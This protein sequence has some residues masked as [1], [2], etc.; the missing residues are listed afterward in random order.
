[1]RDVETIFHRAASLPADERLRYLNAACGSD[2]ALRA[3]VDGLLQADGKAVTFMAGLEN[4]LHAVLKHHQE[5]GSQVGRYRIDRKI[6]AGGMG[7]VYQAWDEKLNRDVALKFLHPHSALDPDAKERFLREARAIS[8]LNHPNICTVFD[9][10]ETD[11]DEQYIVMEFCNGQ[12]LDELIDA[13]KLTYDVNFAIAEQLCDALAIAHAGDILHRDLKPQN[14]IIDQESQVKLLDFGIAKIVEAGAS[15]TSRALGTVSYMSPEQFNAQEQDERTD[16]W[17]LGIL[18]FEMLTGVTPFK[19]KTQPEVMRAIFSKQRLSLH[20][21]GSKLPESFERFFDTCLAHS[22]LDRFSHMNEVKA[23]LS[24]LRLELQH[25]GLANETPKFS[26]LAEDVH[27]LGRSSQNERR[28]ITILHYR[29]LLPEGTDPEDQLILVDQI[30]EI[31]GKIIRRFGAYQYSASTTEL[32]AYFGYP[33]A[34]EHS[35]AQ[36]VRC[37]LALKEATLRR[38]EQ[39]PESYPKLSAQIAVHGGVMI[40]R[41][42]ETSDGVEFIGDAPATAQGLSYQAGPDQILITTTLEELVRGLFAVN[43][44]ATSTGSVFEVLREST[45]KSKF[46]VAVESGLS[47]FCGRVHEL[48]M[49][50]DAWQQTLEH[51]GRV[52]AISGEAGIGKSRLVHE[53]KQ[54]VAE[55]EDAWLVECQCSPHETNNSLYPFL[56]YFQ[57]D[58]LQFSEETTDADK[59]LRVDGFLTEYDFDPD[60]TTVLRDFFLQS[61]NPEEQQLITPDERQRKIF[62]GLRYIL[63]QRAKFQPVLVVLEDMHWADPSSNLM[64]DMMLHNTLPA[65]VM[66]VITFR[67]SFQPRW[68]SAETATRLVLQKLNKRDAQALLENLSLPAKNDVSLGKKLLEKADGNPLFVETLTQAIANSGVDSLDAI[69]KT[70]QASLAA[71]LDQLGEAKI[72]AQYASVI[73]REFELNLLKH[74]VENNTSVVEQ[75]LQQLIDVQIFTPPAGPSS[76]Y[77]FRHA[78]IRDAAYESLLKAD[79]TRIHRQIAEYFT[80]KSGASATLLADHWHLSGEYEQAAKAWLMG[81][82]NALAQAGA[83]E[84]ISLCARALDALEQSTPTPETIETKIDLYLTRSAA[85]IAARGYTD[86]SVETGYA[87]ALELSNELASAEKKFASLF[88][89]STVNVVLGQHSKTLEISNE[90]VAIGERKANTEYLVEAHMV[91]GLAEFFMGEFNACRESFGH[92]IEIYSPESHG[93]HALSYGQD[94]KVIALCHLGWLEFIQGTSAI[95]IETVAR[96]VEHAGSLN[97]QFSQTYALIYLGAIFTFN[98]EIEHASHEI[99][100]ALEICNKHNIRGV[101]ALA[102]VFRSMLDVALEPTN[103][104]IERASKEIGIYEQT[105]AHIYLPA[106]YTDLSLALLQLGEY[107]KAKQLVEK[108]TSIAASSNENWYAYPLLMARAELAA[109]KR[110]ST[111]QEELKEQAALLLKN[112]G[113]TGWSTQRRFTHLQQ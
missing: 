20:N 94:P 50:E 56:S 32:V 100:D 45:A 97:H 101:Q 90:L 95:G 42:S 82:E 12:R 23:Q 65:N 48:G 25:L 38:N 29:A 40:A 36:A 58:V 34:H 88:G 99:N 37:A 22:P 51:E 43:K 77:R 109:Y 107:D 61:V 1:M 84:A 31:F 86:R 17:A 44:I 104:T 62:S 76:A 59:A 113:C 10:A 96:A 53:L 30:N 15:V 63:T 112:S 103:A 91:K 75:V 89:A 39:S 27:T 106:W 92:T 9:V 73:G 33:A 6:A 108:A 41:G 55:S 47:P 7:S 68:L 49:L 54:R 80:E 83:S 78:L 110:T 87:T 4:Q 102:R 52:I 98:G 66:L 3:E 60:G 26:R 74:C 57:R 85:T 8:K 70:L 64:I 16:I 14:V 2:L 46:D 111:H 105:G 21:L 67:P 13:N 28:H 69:P 24:D 11:T 18:F 81:A 79:K 71:R 35:V 19:G 72:V 5:T 93:R